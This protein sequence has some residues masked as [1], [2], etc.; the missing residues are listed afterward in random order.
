MADI[1]C[2]QVVAP[3]QNHRQIQANT[4]LES[5]P[6]WWHNLVDLALA[7]RR[8]RSPV[9]MLFGL[10]LLQVAGKLARIKART[11]QGGV[12]AAH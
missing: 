1:H 9:S 6:S 10:L 2:R 12:Y 11:H 3:A 8:R 7:L 5:M 4:L